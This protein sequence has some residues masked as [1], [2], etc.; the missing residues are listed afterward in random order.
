MASRNRQHL[1]TVAIDRLPILMGICRRF[2]RIQKA[3]LF[4]V[5]IVVGAEIFDSN[6]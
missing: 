3:E 1:M 4:V 2:D 5:Y 6:R